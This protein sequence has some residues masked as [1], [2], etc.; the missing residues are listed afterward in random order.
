MTAVRTLEPSTEN[1][2]ATREKTRMTASRRVSACVAIVRLQARAL[3]LYRTDFLFS[4]LGLLIQI[5]LLRML[6][7]A[8][9]QGAGNATASSLRV[10]LATQIAYTTL[11]NIQHWLF[12]PWPASMIPERVREGT[13]AVDLARPL[14]FPIQMMSAQGGVVLAR[15]PWAL[16]ACP[17]AVFAGGAQPPASSGALIAAVVSLVLALWLTLLLSLIVG[18]AAFWTLEVSGLLVVYGHLSEFLAGVLVPPWLMP[19]WLHVITQWLPFQAITY[20]PVATYLG[21][22][23]NSAH[24]LGALG[25]QCGWIL[26]AWIT[27]R[28]IW[29]RAL[30][31]IVVQGG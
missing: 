22:L 14:R 26:V 17:L 21:R 16:V 27:M 6:W 25:V 3:R 4:L 11:A 7:T 20:T 10:G 24:V 5:Y 31:R 1:R 15:L 8:A 29:S 23:G 2:S 13:V 12:N 28:A 19:S 9:Y 18:M 30:H